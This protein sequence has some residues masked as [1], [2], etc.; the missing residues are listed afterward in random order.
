MLIIK[1]RSS[2]CSDC[3]SDGQIARQATAMPSL[4]R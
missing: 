3:D 2:G 1:V 4:D